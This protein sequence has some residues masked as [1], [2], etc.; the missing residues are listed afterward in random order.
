MERKPHTK[1]TQKY[2]PQHFV[3]RS[4]N[5]Q[6]YSYE[7]LNHYFIIKGRKQGRTG[8]KQAH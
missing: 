3:M 6:T 4:H 8:L 7:Q 5:F 1:Q 2:T